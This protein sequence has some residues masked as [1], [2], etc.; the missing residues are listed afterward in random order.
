[1]SDADK[2]IRQQVLAGLVLVAAVCLFLLWQGGYL[3]PRQVPV[4]EGNGFVVPEH[5]I[6]PEYFANAKPATPIS[7]SAMVTIVISQE[8]YERFSPA[9]KP[10]IVVVPVAYLD[11]TNNFTNTTALPT[12]HEEKSLRPEGAVAMIR[13]PVTMYDRFLADAK[14]ATME[15]PESS[16]VRRYDNLSALYAQVRPGDTTVGGAVP[17][18]GTGMPGVPAVIDT[19]PPDPAHGYHHNT[20]GVLGASR[21][22]P[23]S[24]HY[25]RAG[26]RRG[27]DIAPEEIGPR[28][29]RGGEPV[30]DGC[31]PAY[32]V[33]DKNLRG[34]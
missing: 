14:G 24:G 26:H 30:G 1:M 15:L 32:R 20:P 7:E 27:M 29:G 11:F 31:R 33:P 9:D 12:W 8:T 28:C 6:P 13:M 18:G 21:Q 17:T 34:R 2:G 5:H 22:V 19:T 3:M 10:G 4:P 25:E 16:F 23:V